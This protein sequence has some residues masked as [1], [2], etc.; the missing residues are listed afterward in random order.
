L[1][2]GR[3]CGGRFVP[4]LSCMER[5]NVFHFIFYYVWRSGGRDPLGESCLVTSF[6][7]CILSY[8]RVSDWKC[9]ESEV[10]LSFSPPLLLLSL[11]S[12]WRRSRS[13][14]QRRYSSPIFFS[15]PQIIM[16]LCIEFGIPLKCS[17]YLSFPKMSSFRSNNQSGGGYRTR[18]PIH[19]FMSSENSI[20]L[21]LFL[22]SS[23]FPRPVS[24]LP[25][26]SV[27]LGLLEAKH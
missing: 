24:Q 22:L 16:L 21:F 6:L 3:E 13:R 8:S 12:R 10:C 19:L 23:S 20:F 18:G 11:L 27:S 14:K 7:P 4:V 1:I 25:P 17:K 2:D 15:Y 26:S 5:L 9:G